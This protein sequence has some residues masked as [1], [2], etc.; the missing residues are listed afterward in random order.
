[1]TDL[2]LEGVTKRFGD[3]VANDNIDLRV[4][5]GS[6]HAVLGENGAGKTTL[7]RLMAG[8]MTRQVSCRRE[9]P[10]IRP[11]STISAST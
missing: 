2:R 9:Q 3:C 11:N 4:A 10:A 5:T 6:I 1:M 8:I 7:M